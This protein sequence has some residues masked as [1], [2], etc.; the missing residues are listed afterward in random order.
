MGV[1]KGLQALVDALGGRFVVIAVRAEGGRRELLIAE[2]D[3]KAR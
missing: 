2:A 1:A 3:L